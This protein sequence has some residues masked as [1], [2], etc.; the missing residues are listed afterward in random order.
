MLTPRITGILRKHQGQVSRT[1][2]L[3]TELV[4]ERSF[5]CQDDRVFHLWPRKQAHQAVPVRKLQPLP[6]WDPHHGV[7]TSNPFHLLTWLSWRL[8]WVCVMVSPAGHMYVLDMGETGKWRVLFLLKLGKIGFRR[9]RTR[10][11]GEGITG[12]GITMKTEADCC[13]VIEEM[14]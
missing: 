14:S 3:T 10:G 12:A 8:P 7:G 13:C 1:H 6:L 2:F 9:R 11:Y 4:W 5:G